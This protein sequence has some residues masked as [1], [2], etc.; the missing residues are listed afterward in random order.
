M[1]ASTQRSDGKSAPT[2]NPALPSPEVRGWIN[3]LLFMHLFAVA[4]GL[5]A[6][7]SPSP[8]QDRLR[9]VFGPYLGTLNF[10]LKPNSY[11]TG[12]YFQT[13]GNEN[14]V[15]F[16]LEIVG[17]LPDGATKTELVPD[18]GLWPGER[19]YFQAIANAAGTMALSG[20]D[21]LESILPRSIAGSLLK[22]WGAVRGTVSCKSHLPLT[23]EEVD[24]GD[25]HVRDPF[26]PR[27]YR[28]IYE[29]HVLVSSDGQVDVLKKAAAGEVAPVE[30]ER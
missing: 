16:Q 12:R 9:K 28:T 17:T 29:A 27:R 8:L 19:Q 15:D 21:E 13:Y 2:S 25:A 6:Y 4:V 10:D 1:P 20:N 18:I 30:K 22:Q 14:D 11:P 26:D 7:A 5:T 24:S 23:P 3:L